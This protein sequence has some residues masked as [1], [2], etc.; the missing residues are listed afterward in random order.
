MHI[1][2]EVLATHN[3]TQ[4]EYER[5]KQLMEREPTFVELGIF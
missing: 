1:T 2:P 4:D 3:L 5:I